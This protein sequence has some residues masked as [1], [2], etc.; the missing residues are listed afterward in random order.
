MTQP[1][2]SLEQDAAAAFLLQPAQQRE[3]QRVIQ[4]QHV[5][6]QDAVARALEKA[7]L[8]LLRELGTRIFIAV[9]LAI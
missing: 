2:D 4:H 7:D 1:K 5:R 8:V 6:G 9:S 3:E